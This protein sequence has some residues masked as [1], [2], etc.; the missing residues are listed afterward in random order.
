MRYLTFGGFLRE[1]VKSLSES[2]TISI[3]KLVRESAENPRLFEP[4]C[5]YC[6][7]ADKTMLYRKYS[8]K[9][10]T[11]YDEVAEIEKNELTEML[12][13]KK[14]SHNYQKVMTSFLAIKQK[15]ETESNVKKLI[16]NRII[17]IQKKNGISNYRIY[18]DLKLNPGNVN[19]WIKNGN[20]QKI[21]I[22]KARMILSF[23]EQ[24][25]ESGSR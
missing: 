23:V 17:D 24:Y 11:E 13:S 3:E 12:E 9:Y 2:N 21:G 4:L 6:V 22:E 20:D 18:K 15:K 25:G 1:Y 5:L 14:L 8:K 16:R 19:D 10:G 7:F